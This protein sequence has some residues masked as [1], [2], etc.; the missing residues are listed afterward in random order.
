M[1]E[2]QKTINSLDN[3]PNQPSNFSAKIRIYINDE[4]RGTYTTNS[5]MKFKTTML[6]SSLYD[7][8]DVYILVKGAITIT[9]RKERADVSARQEARLADK[10]NKVVTF[11]N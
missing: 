10:R 5:Q 4:W 9:G 7:Y 6:K 2:Y 8:S 11:K 3:S 1:T